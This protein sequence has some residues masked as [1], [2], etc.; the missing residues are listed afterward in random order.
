MDERYF[1]SG[2]LTVN[3]VSKFR[4][5]H[6]SNS[7]RNMTDSAL[8]TLFREVDDL[9]K[10][11]CQTYTGARL[12]RIFDWT[13]SNIDDDISSFTQNLTTTELDLFRLCSAATR[14]Y[15]LWMMRGSRRIFISDCAVKLMSSQTSRE[16][17]GKV[18]HDP[19]NRLNQQDFSTIKRIR[20]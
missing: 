13:M 11:L 19:S 12:R 5:R 20:V 4:A 17:R 9:E 1:I 8:S 15:S 3:L 2:M 16:N 7:R 6:V 10:C 18:N 14:A